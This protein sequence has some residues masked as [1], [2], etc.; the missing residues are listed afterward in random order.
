MSRKIYF[1]EGPYLFISLSLFIYFYLS[2]YIF[3]PIE[4]V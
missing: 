2:T 3:N 4:M 1:Y